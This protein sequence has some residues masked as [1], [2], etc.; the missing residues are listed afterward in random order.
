MSDKPIH[1]PIRDYDEM[2]AAMEDPTVALI[3]Q[4]LQT[5][6]EVSASYELDWEETKARLDKLIQTLPTMTIMQCIDVV[7]EEIEDEHA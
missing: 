4:K 5:L 2:R 7:V 6:K 3:A 1:I